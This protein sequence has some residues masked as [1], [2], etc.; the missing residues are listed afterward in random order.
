MVIEP[1]EVKGFEL[2]ARDEDL[3]VVGVLL[4]NGDSRVSRLARENVEELT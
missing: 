3:V 4:V 2:Q 1:L